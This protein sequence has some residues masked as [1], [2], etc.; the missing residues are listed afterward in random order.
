MAVAATRP[1]LRERK[2]RRTEQT[3]I[4]TATDLFAKQGY[5]ATT[6]AE[7][8]DAAE[9]SASTVFKYFPTKAD[10]VFNLIDVVTDNLRQR[11]ETRR[12]A[13][14]TAAAVVAWVL[15]DLPR[16]EMPYAELLRGMPRLVA[17]EPE[18]Q[19][20]SRLRIARVED[21]LAGGFGADLDEPAES[22][23]V[24]VLAT[25]ATRAM[26]DVWS[27]W[28]AQHEADQPFDLSTMFAVKAEY[29]RCALDAGLAAIETLPRP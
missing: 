3:I 18:L 2:K 16:L 13:E 25:I 28:H 5:A 8:A 20:Q 1:S 11:I 21:V 4:A 6:V 9:V 22:M 27:A 12:G 19:A 15:E 26:G 23:R 24:R 29:V 10:L 7:V 17:S 14:T